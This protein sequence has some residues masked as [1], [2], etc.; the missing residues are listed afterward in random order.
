MEFSSPPLLAELHRNCLTRAF[1][2]SATDTVLSQAKHADNGQMAR[3]RSQYI[4]LCAGFRL[5]ATKRISRYTLECR[6]S[7]DRTVPCKLGG[8]GY[9]DTLAYCALC[10]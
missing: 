4:E 3:T 9:E 7:W 1:A 6:E 8:H 2:L 10:Y 5:D